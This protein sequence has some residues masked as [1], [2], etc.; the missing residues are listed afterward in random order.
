MN[1]PSDYFSIQRLIELQASRTPSATAVVFREQSLTYAALNQAANRLGHYLQSLG[2][3]PDTVVGVWLERSL[4]MVVSLLA[5][6]KAGG[7]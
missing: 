7:A 4:E 3:G 1:M 2:V 5:I 6:L